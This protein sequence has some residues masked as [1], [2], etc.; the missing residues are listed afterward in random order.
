[1]SI[2]YS[3]LFYKRV[4]HI[5][6]RHL[7]WCLCYYLYLSLIHHKFLW[8]LLI[9]AFYPVDCI[10]FS[11][12]LFYLILPLNQQELLLVEMCFYQYKYCLCIFLWLEIN[13][14][15]KMHILH[16]EHI[17]SLYYHRFHLNDPPKMVHR[18]TW[19][20]ANDI[21]LLKC[22]RFEKHLVVIVASVTW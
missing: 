13:F 12:L 11:F 9:R 18:S 2:H 22:I 19:F 21:V 10:V 7:S 17:R 16:Q 14:V 20:H 8:Y 4:G 6:K 15:V 3:K 1:M 5:N